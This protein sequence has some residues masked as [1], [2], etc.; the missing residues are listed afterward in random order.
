M[1]ARGDAWKINL[2]EAAEDT[3]G[4]DIPDSPEWQ[5][6]ALMPV[7][8]DHLNADVLNG[9]VYI[10]GSEHGHGVGY[11]QHREVQIYDIASN[12]WRLGA[13]LPTGSSH[14]RSLVHDNRIWVF[15]GQRETQLVLDEVRS[16]DPVA[17]TWKLH[18]PMPETRKAGYVFFHENQFFYVAGDAFLRGFP[19]RTLI[20]TLV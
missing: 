9:K 4:D 19:L 14:N 11:V 6:I 3:D 10:T 16:Y 18:D 12:S 1:V 7:P 13:P 2:S 17:N 8:G 5:P 20:G 15:G